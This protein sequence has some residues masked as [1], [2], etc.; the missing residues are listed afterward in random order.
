MPT[1]PTEL[2]ADFILLSDKTNHVIVCLLKPLLQL[3]VCMHQAAQPPVRS[4]Q[5]HAC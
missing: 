3:A 5:E 2:P 1:M 4:R